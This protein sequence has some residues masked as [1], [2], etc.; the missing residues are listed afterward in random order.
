MTHSEAN[1]VRLGLLKKRRN[2]QD[3]SFLTLDFDD[4]G[5]GCHWDNRLPTAD[6][7]LVK[8]RRFFMPLVLRLALNA[9]WDEELEF[10]AQGLVSP[11]PRVL[12]SQIF[13][14]YFL[15]DPQLFCSDIV[16]EKY[17]AHDRA[18]FVYQDPLVYGLLLEPVEGKCGLYR[19]VCMVG[20]KS[21]VP[22][23][24]HPG[25]VVTRNTAKILADAARLFQPDE[26]R[27][28]RTSETDPHVYQISIC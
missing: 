16:K 22:G 14:H 8:S 23:A 13:A 28:L 26:G 7:E 20:L 24:V 3:Q 11:E 2:S 4:G 18:L 27:I 17:R 10:L 25:N 1:R 5:S 15:T 9:V 12:T 19:R 21:Y 6:Q